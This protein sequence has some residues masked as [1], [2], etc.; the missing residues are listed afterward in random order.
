MDLRKEAA[1]E[2]IRLLNEAGYEAYLVGG[3]VR[4]L[5]LGRI[6]NDFDVA[7]SATPP[8]V[9]EIFAR[10]FATGI[11]HGTVT[12]VWENEPVEVTTFRAEGPYI[13]HRRP[14]EVL[15]VRSLQDDLQRRDF[16]INAMA[17]D[18]NGKLYDYFGGQ[19]DLKNGLI[20]TVG[21][22]T[23]RF[24]EDALRMIRAARF[25]AQFSFRIDP[26]TWDAMHHCSQDTRY[27]SVERVTAELDKILESPAP[28]IGLQALFQTNLFCHMPPFYRWQ[29]S[30][31][32]VDYFLRHVPIQ[33]SRAG[34]WV[35]LLQAFDTT[36]SQVENRVREC[37]LSKK[38]FVL[39]RSIM[40]I[41]SEWSEMEKTEESW[42]KS[43]LLRYGLEPVIESF[44]IKHS[45]GIEV[46]QLYQWWEEMP[47]KK[48][49]DLDLH[50]NELISFVGKPAGP[51]VKKV[52]SELCRY[53]ALGEIPNQKETLLKV[54]KQIV[55]EYS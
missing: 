48:V 37:K 25:A 32:K 34:K 3:C 33:C 47:V 51:W 44:Y 54:G 8:E 40:E 31:E 16:T 18:L 41:L 28:H 17:M 20:R 42:L 43:L 39:F 6:P 29:W 4:D 24:H 1:Y 11:E 2:V 45:S 10:S 46:I 49:T 36:V 30:P 50:G 5:L 27:L 55:A 13:D 53:A 22:A 52:L 7:T 26:L 21:D 19:I 15:F 35:W 12:V 38:D 14:S 23:D 9:Q